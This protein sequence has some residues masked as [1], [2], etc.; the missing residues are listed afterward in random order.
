[1]EDN[2]LPLEI[3]VGLSRE[4]YVR[5]MELLR[6]ATRQNNPLGNH[7]IGLAM[8]ALC[9]IVVIVDCVL[10]KQVDAVMIVLLLLLFAV[11]VAMWIVT[12]KTLRERDAGIYEQTL[13]TGYS[14]NGIL[15]IGPVDIRKQ[16]MAGQVAIS[17]FNC[18]LFV[19]AEDMMIF[20][21]PRGNSIVL[22]ARFLTEEDADLLR[23]LAFE[24]IPPANRR[25]FGKL[26]PTAVEHGPL[27][28]LIPAMD[29]LR[30]AM[31][32]EYTLKEHQNLL[33]EGV[34][35]LL[36]Q[37]ALSQL[38]IAAVGSL[39]FYTI[40][41][42]AGAVFLLFWLV[43]TLTRLLVLPQM[44]L[45]RAVKATNGAELRYAVKLTREGLYVKKQYD[46][47]RPLR[48]PWYCMTRVVETP[49]TVEFYTTKKVLTIPKRCIPDW[50]EFQQVVD[51]RMDATRPQ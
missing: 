30:Y 7:W 2:R 24:H 36:S 38:L 37:T 31:T 18:P 46:D 41:P 19:E 50:D 28:S 48:Y 22:P 8:M 3:P 17:Y 29:E 11:E 13:F 21:V 16:T 20:A 15:H 43:F 27:P 14:F 26:V 4:E 25:L 42:I 49:E 10:T 5:F 40:Y 6:K 34:M 51:E 35:D 39:I 23:S 9:I 1:M 32:V 47:A 12:P 44:R 33:H 45:K